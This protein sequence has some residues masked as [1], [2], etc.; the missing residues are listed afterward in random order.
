MRGSKKSEKMSEKEAGEGSGSAPRSP[1][2]VMQILMALAQHPDGTTLTG[3]S[4]ALALPKTTVFNLLRSLA[5]GGYVNSIDGRLH[6]GSEAIKLGVALQNSQ[7][8]PGNVRP[9]CA[10]LGELTEETIVISTLSE[11]FLEVYF[12]L[13]LEASNPLRFDV[14][15]GQRW[16]SYSTAMGQVMLAYLPPA[17]QKSYLSSVDIKRL[18]ASTISSRKALAAALAQARQAGSA[19]NVN[20]MIDGVMGVAAPIFDR[21]GN[22]HA[23]V[24]VTAPTVR[25][26]EKRAMAEPAIRATGEEISRVLGFTGPYPPPETLEHLAR[27]RPGRRSR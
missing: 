16:P 10:Q 4:Q 19:T 18:T 7:P 9:L 3:L 21:D 25:M 2:R 13:V 5:S 15:A 1:L 11:D 26:L 17:M 6:V 20:G 22:I 23:A 24:A 14:R 12:L 27:A 8:F